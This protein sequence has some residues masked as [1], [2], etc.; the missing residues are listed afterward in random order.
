[1]IDL[2]ILL[3]RPALK[4]VEGGSRWPH[5][6]LA[7][8]I[9]Y[10]VDLAICNTYWRYL[11]GPKQGREKT[12]SDTLERLCKEEGERQQLFIEIAKEINRASPTGNHIKAVG[13]N[14]A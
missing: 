3:L 11:A 4:C 13:T 14:H 9:A 12:I 2:L 1:M 7:A 8:L 10:L 6:I 5:H